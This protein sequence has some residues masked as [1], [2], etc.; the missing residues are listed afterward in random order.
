[1]STF[2]ELCKDLV[3]EAG[4]S[5][6]GPTTVVSQSGEMGRVV[7]WIA[8]AYLELQDK[9]ANWDFHRT[10]F[11]SPLVIGTTT[12]T[13]LAL[14]PALTD[15]GN[16][17]IDTFRCYNTTTGLND[18]KWMTFIP[19]QTFRDA[20]L[21]SA[22]R[23][24]QGR[25]MRFTVRPEDKAIVTFPI[26]DDTYTIEGEYFKRAQKMTVDTDQPLFPS[27]YHA[28]LV[29]RALMFYGAFEGA[30]EV[31]AHGSSEYLKLL[32]VLENDQT[33]EVKTGPA[34]A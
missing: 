23:N 21:F 14:T 12:Y 17:A 16:W 33:P 8:K 28:I 7:S 6:S 5:G 1:M 11:S 32:S 18:E 29:W 22:N 10:D 26:P 19:W 27:Q 31:Y 34:M 24:V 2:L 9:K 25:P 13:A 15:H 30:P 4:I 20:Y 3:M